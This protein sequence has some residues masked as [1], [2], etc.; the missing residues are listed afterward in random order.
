[1]KRPL[2]ILLSLFIAANLLVAVQFVRRAASA[3]APA[4][5]RAATQ[6]P[7]QA[8]SA[9]ARIEVWDEPVKPPRP[10]RVPIRVPGLDMDRTSLP[11]GA[12]EWIFLTHEAPGHD[13]RPCGLDG[14]GPVLVLRHYLAEKQWASVSAQG[15]KGPILA[16]YEIVDA[17][18][19]ALPYPFPELAKQPGAP[20]LVTAVLYWADLAPED[21]A[22]PLATYMELKM[23]KSRPPGQAPFLQLG[24][25]AMTRVRAQWM[26]YEVRPKGGVRLQQ[27]NGRQRVASGQ[28]GWTVDEEP[29]L[30][31]EGTSQ[32][33]QTDNIVPV[34]DLSISRPIP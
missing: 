9:T 22:S 26:E 1:M 21:R 14:L 33:G 29:R 23:H 11:K 15:G 6:G 12:P 20:Y 10:T 13:T 31:G 5:A 3:A 2:L 19:L 7:P 30:S 25:P 34:Y 18:S 27:L 17:E 32:C 16:R 28:A 24:G 8:A 4:Q